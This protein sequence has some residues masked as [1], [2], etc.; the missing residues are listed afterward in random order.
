MCCCAE[1]PNING[2]PGYSWDGKTIG[3]RPVHPPT[4]AEQ[5]VLVFDEPGRC[6]G[7]DAH[8]HHF[9]VVKRLSR[10]VLLVAHGAG[11]ESID[12]GVGA[13]LILGTLTG[14]DTNARY[15]MLHEFYSLH[16]EAA[17]RATDKIIAEW[18]QAAAEKRI[19][20]RKMRGR[21]GVKV[22]VEPKP[23]TAA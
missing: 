12:L 14:L 10:Y 11:E 3:T 15:W 19:K 16:R 4:L 23:Q 6:G 22:W 13:R 17:S 2:N 7:M 1:R 21:N 18:R 9:C 20:T 8:S 5:D